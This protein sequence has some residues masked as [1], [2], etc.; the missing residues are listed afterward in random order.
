[1]VGAHFTELGPLKNGLAKARRVDRT[2]KLYGYI[3]L[4]GRYAIAPAFKWADDFHDGRAM[5][6][7]DYLVEFINTQGKTTTTFGVLCDQIVIFDAE[8]NQSWPREALTCSDATRTDPPALDTA[9]A[10]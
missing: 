10:E 1:M 6:M 3:D 2:G 5:V 9:K 4:S 7:H 8:E